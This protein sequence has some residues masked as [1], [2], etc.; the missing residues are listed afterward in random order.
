MFGLGYAVTILDVTGTPDIDDTPPDWGE[1]PGTLPAFQTVT[2][3]E[4]SMV[5]VNGTMIQAATFRG[6]SWL[7]SPRVFVH[8]FGGSTDWDE[9]ARTATFTGI[10]TAGTDVV[11]T[12]TLNS[13]DM[14]VNGVRH[15]IAT[16][17]GQAGIL[18][19]GSIEPFMHNDRMYVPARALANSFGIRIT[20]N[21]GSVTIG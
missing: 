3:V 8:L 21:A 9:A 2:F 18:G 12:F 4:S 11:V 17:V 10:T 5:D 16:F 13:S 15:D 7:I 19:A 14:T 20:G 6:N 1:A